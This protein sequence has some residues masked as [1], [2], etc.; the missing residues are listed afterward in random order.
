[1][2]V[3]Y[4][5]AYFVACYFSRYAGF[6]IDDEEDMSFA[7]GGHPNLDQRESAKCGSTSEGCRRQWKF[8]QND[9]R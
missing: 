5:W 2:V 9:G 4:Y 7:A 8:G 3:Q 1:V 6:A